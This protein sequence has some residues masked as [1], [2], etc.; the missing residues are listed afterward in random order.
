MFLRFAALRGMCACCMA[1]GMAWRWR[2]GMPCARAARC[3]VTLRFVRYAVTP[4]CAEQHGGARTRR[5]ARAAAS[6]CRA[7]ISGSSVDLCCSCRQIIV[8]CVAGVW[9]ARAAVAR[10]GAHARAWRLPLYAK[11]QRA[12]SARRWRAGAGRH[13]MARMAA[14]SGA[15]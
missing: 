10:A 6:A 13:G 1:R 7:A 14:A 3:C 9:R 5:G 4:R 12:A 11:T 15:M 8:I 2:H